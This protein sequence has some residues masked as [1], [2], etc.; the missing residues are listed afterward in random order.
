MLVPILVRI[1]LQPMES[2]KNPEVSFFVVAMLRKQSQT[3]IK[4]RNAGESD[5]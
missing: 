1:N 2:S 3:C 5:V 4:I